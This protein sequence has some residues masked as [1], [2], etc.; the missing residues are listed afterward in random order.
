VALLAVC[1]I[2]TQTEAIRLESAGENELEGNLH[3]GPENQN[4]ALS[5]AF[6][7]LMNQT[8]ALSQAI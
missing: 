5:S 4:S 8:N 6:S 2:L 3:A 7:V 1:G